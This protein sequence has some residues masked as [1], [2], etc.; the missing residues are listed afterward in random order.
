MM[1]NIKKYL[2]KIVIATL[3]LCI[4]FS[5]LIIKKTYAN[6]YREQ[7][8]IDN[9]D[10]GR[11]PGYKD[12]LRELKNQHPNWNFTI[13]YTGLDWDT[14]V[15][16]ETTAHHGRSLIQ[17]KSGEWLCSTCGN[18]VYD[19]SNWYCASTKALSY[20]LDPRNFL[21]SSNVYQ[22]ETLSYIDG[23]YT[24]EGIESILNGTFMNNQSIRAYYNNEN[25]VDAKFSTIII[26]AGKEAGVSPYHIASRIKQEIIISGGGPS[27]SV[28][29]NIEGYEGYFNFFNIGA[30]SGAGAVERGLKYAQAKGWNSPEKSIKEGTKTIAKN[31]IGRGQNTLY[32]EKF[33]VDSSDNSLYSHQYQQNIQAPTNEGKRIYSAYLNLGMIEQNY[34]FV[35]PFYENMPNTISALPQE[36][37][38]IVTENVELNKDGIMFRTEDNT[39]A[40]AICYVNKGDKLLRIEKGGTYKDG[41]LWDK[42]VMDDG[43]KGYIE[44]IYLNKL[45]DIVNANDAVYV[46]DNV[47]LRNGPGL[48]GTTVITK[49]YSGTQLTRIEAGKYVL[50]G[51]TWDRVKLA[52]GS[53]GYLARK[54]LGES[55]SDLKGEIVKVIA[56]GSLKLR[57]QPTTDSAVITSLTTGSL[58]TRLEKNVAN[59]NG[60][61]W[62]K[63]QT[64]SGKIG[65]VASKYLELVQNDEP[66]NPTPTPEPEPTPANNFWMDDY[67]KII[68]CSPEVTL[69]IIKKGFNEKS[70]NAKEKNGTEIADGTRLIGTG[71]IVTID[72][73]EYQVVKYGD[74]NGDG[75]VDARDSLRILKYV[76]GEY[77][78]D[79]KVYFYAADVSLD[80]TVDARDSLRI[81]KYTVG[82]YE[83][84]A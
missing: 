55:S 1:L 84:R 33:D 83:I 54:F 19:G 18:K 2:E 24:E 35:I 81:L 59:A 74:V 13:L 37:F 57:E 53:Q 44:T 72:G 67:N 73:C 75:T 28:S 76:V 82:E 65:Y 49:L 10:E 47:N 80:N 50:D 69:E 42:V 11:Y 68:N 31:Y 14:V 7:T 27:G 12:K 26:E 52:D 41:L 61:D 32:L 46:K 60:L 20:Y 22:F 71:M 29:G 66:I 79:E 30:T 34:N 17:N 21:D 39:W 48:S 62:D 8:N 51:Y 58:L 5:T 64:V 3:I 15:Y 63:V 9:I 56:N 43:R 40:P 25:Y 36:G 23:A 45:D 4:I 78:L 6:Q 70:V 77:N 16:N 38:T